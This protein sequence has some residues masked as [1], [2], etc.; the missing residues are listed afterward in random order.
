MQGPVATL[1]DGGQ[2]LHLQHGPIDLIIGAEAETDASV[3]RAFAAAEARFQTVL[4]GLVAQLAL[5]RA[6]LTIST[7]LPADQTARRMYRAAR[8]FC[9]TDF[10]TPMIAVAGSVADEI[11]NAMLAEG[12]L[13]RAYVNNGGDIAVHLADGAT[14]S[15]AMAHVQGKDLGRIRI[16]R[17]SGI[18]GIA[19]SGAGGRSFSLGI[20]DSVTVLAPNAATADVAATLIA[21]A[22][23][24]P[25][26]PGVTRVPADELLPDSDL[27]AQ[28]VVTAVPDLTTKDREVALATGRQR[29]EQ[30]LNEGQII[31]AALFL[32]GEVAQ[33]GAPFQGS[34]P[35]MEIEYA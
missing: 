9:T 25:D 27:G 15:V 7:G 31:G 8:P 17:S 21:N 12:P 19:T 10:L 18:R 6:R 5:H 28:L 4:D 29:A 33:T 20:A 24:L 22:A 2:R 11:L 34:G 23:D 32:Q 14:F 16:D 3:K 1:L 30:M 13:R 35:L 26:H